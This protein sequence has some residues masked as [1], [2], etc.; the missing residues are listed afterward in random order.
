MDIKVGEIYTPL[1]GPFSIS[2]GDIRII[3]ICGKT[4]T[5]VYLNPTI[6]TEGK[7]QLQIDNRRFSKEYLILTKVKNSKLY[8]ALND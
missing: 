5:Y 3:N 7:Y 2:S 1:K 4:I 6:D 8:K